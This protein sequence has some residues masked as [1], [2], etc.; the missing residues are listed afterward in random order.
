MS[1]TRTKSLIALRAKEVK[2]TAAGNKDTK[3]NSSVKRQQ[4][5]WRVAKSSQQDF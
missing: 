1:L 5:S 2:K 3:K 4:V